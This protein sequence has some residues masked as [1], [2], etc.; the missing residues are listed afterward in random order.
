MFGDLDF[1]FFLVTRVFFF[2]LVNADDALLPRCYV[3]GVLACIALPA[4]ES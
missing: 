1:D 3:D 4:P 2:C